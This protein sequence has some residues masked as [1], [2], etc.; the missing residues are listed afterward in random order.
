MSRHKRT[1]APGAERFADAPLDGSLLEVADV[2]TQFKTPR[3]LVHAVDGV[4]FTL[5]RGK[6]IGIVGESGCGKSVLSRSIMGLLPTN[7]VR[8]GSIRFEG[9][10]IGQAASNEM[11]QYWGTQMSIVFQDAD[12]F[13]QP[14]HARSATRSRSRCG[15]T[16]TSPR[17]TRRRPRWPCS[18]RSGFPKPSAGCGSIRTNS[19]AAC[20]SAS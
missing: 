8:Y 10:E 14:G 4:S 12:D 7:V 20:A 13:A 9:N 16:S 17:T 3:G 5:E 18:P 2:K 11:R 15:S 1:A 6:T 19:R